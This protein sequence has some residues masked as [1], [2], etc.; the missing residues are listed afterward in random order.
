MLGPEIALLGLMVFILLLIGIGAYCT[1]NE[2]NQQ[3]EKIKKALDRHCGNL[4]DK[5]R[6]DLEF[7][8]ECYNILKE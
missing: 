3:L 6:E 8:S 7:L 1:I 2:S 4:K 5:P